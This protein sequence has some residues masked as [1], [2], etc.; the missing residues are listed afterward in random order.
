MLN[1]QI[2]TIP[3]C[4]PIKRYTEWMEM[5]GALLN[6]R[7]IGCGIN[8]MTFLKYLSLEEG[9]DEVGKLKYDYINSGLCIG[10][11]Y[12]EI[13]S[14]IKRESLYPDQI[15][16]GKYYFNYNSKFDEKYHQSLVKFFNLMFS[17][18]PENTCTVVKFLRN[19]DKKPCLSSSPGHSFVLGKLNK[20]LYII[21]PQN[22]VL[23]EIIN[24]GINKLNITTT[25][26]YWMQCYAYAEYVTL[27]SNKDYPLMKP[28]K[29]LFRRK[30]RIIF[31]L[32]DSGYT[33][34]N[35]KSRSK[36]RSKSRKRSSR[37]PRRR[38]SRR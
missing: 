18:L 17:G 38:R 20:K 19:R 23:K 7:N 32:D 37:N 34:S 36:S 4:N 5:G 10:T 27:L 25:R 31:P 1:I 14:Y 24:K 16:Y 2:A 15:N 9:K 12:E 29:R 35:I 22:G 26:K 30:P 21:D 6:E 8:S 28:K 33:R 11:P 3:D 13:I